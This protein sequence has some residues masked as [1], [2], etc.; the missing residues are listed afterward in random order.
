MTFETII[1][2]SFGRHQERFWANRRLL[3][4]TEVTIKLAGVIIQDARIE[5]K[6]ACDQYTSSAEEGFLGQELL[7]DSED[8]GREEE[9]TNVNL[10]ILIG[11][12]FIYA[13]AN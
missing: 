3:V 7:D 4:N 13:D 12:V 10:M 1:K 11:F 2:R 5:Q 6:L 8:E 9:M